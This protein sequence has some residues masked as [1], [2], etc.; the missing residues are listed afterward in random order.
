M[1]ELGRKALLPTHVDDTKLG[2]QPLPGLNLQPCGLHMALNMFW[3]GV[4]LSGRGSLT[5]T[6]KLSGR[7][8]NSFQNLIHVENQPKKCQHLKLFFSSIKS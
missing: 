2:S 5:Y 3:P 7:S 8:S 4:F 1:C 6:G